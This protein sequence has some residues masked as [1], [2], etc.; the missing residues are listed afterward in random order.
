[1]AK[2]LEQ[3]SAV[4]LL[5]EAG[6][7]LRHVPLDTLLCHWIGS[8]PFA[9]AVLLFWNDQSHNNSDSRCAAGALV[10]AL[11]LVWMNCWRAVYAGRLHRMLSGAADRP[12]DGARVRNLIA[13]QAFLAGVKMVLLPLALLAVFPFATTVAFFR[14]A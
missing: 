5:E 8:A 13:N 14:N 12:W 9:L 10:L 7:L 11:L 1:M 4:T 6:H 2:P 3:A